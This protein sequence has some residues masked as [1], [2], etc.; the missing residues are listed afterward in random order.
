[1]DR[2]WNAI[3]FG[4]C[5]FL[6][7]LTLFLGAI[8]KSQEKI[9]MKAIKSIESGGDPQAVSSA[10]A[11]G[12]YQIM[13]ITLEDYNQYHS[14]TYTE[15]DLFD[16]EINKK[17]AVWYIQDRIPEL[18]EYYN[19]ELTVENILWAYNAGIG[20]VRD[21]VK[22]EETIRYIEKYKRLTSN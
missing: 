20:R 16:P 4:I 7:L 13:P 5:I 11:V 19:L 9:D 21:G 15:D 17:I 1:M 14:N 12:L 6:I 22:P 8:A 2:D 3:A 18:L 10:G